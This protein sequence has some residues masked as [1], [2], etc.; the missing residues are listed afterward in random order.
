MLSF[1]SQPSSPGSPNDKK[2]RRKL[3]PIPPGTE[4]SPKQ[5]PKPKPATPPKPVVDKAAAEK[6][7]LRKRLQEKSA[8]QKKPPTAT[9]TPPPTGK[10]TKDEINTSRKPTTVVKKAQPSAASRK[11]AI[12]AVAKKPMQISKT[13]QPTIAVRKTQA[14]PVATSSARSTTV[15]SGPRSTTVTSGPKPTPVTSGPRPTPVT[16]T[17]TTK[18]PPLVKKKPQVAQKPKA[19]KPPE[20]VE[21]FG[22]KV[23]VEIKSLKQRIKEE[24]Q[25]VTATRRLRMDEME[26][27]RRMELELGQRDRERRKKAEQEAQEEALR[28]AERQ[29]QQELENERQR[30]N[31]RLATEQKL[32]AER[33]YASDKAKF[34]QRRKVTPQVAAI[35]SRMSPQA[36]P[37]R[38]RHKR[39]NSD[40]MIA[41]FSPIEEDRDI[42]GELQYKLG[43]ETR[44]VINDITKLSPRPGRYSKRLGTVTPP[45]RPEMEDDPVMS[46]SALSKS[47]EILSRFSLVERDPTLSSSLSESC[48]PMSSAPRSRT[49]N[50]FS[51]DD[52]QKKKEEK[53]QQLRLEI[54]KRKQQIEENARLQYELRKMAE[55][56][57][58]TRREFEEA[59]DM[60]QDHI[61]LRER[62]PQS[63]IIRPIDYEF[64]MGLPEQYSNQEY[65]A[66]RAMMENFEQAQVHPCQQPNYSSSEYLA[67]CRSDFPPNHDPSMMV[68]LDAGQYM[69]SN[70]YPENNYV[71]AH[72]PPYSQQEVVLYDSHPGSVYPAGYPNMQDH[73]L[74]GGNLPVGHQ[75]IQKQSERDMGAP[76]PEFSDASSVPT[77]AEATPNSERPPAMPLLEEV[78][79]RSRCL[80]RD[81]GSR[82][83]SDDMEKYF[84]AEGTSKNI[85]PIKNTLIAY[86]SLTNICNSLSSSYQTYIEIV[87]NIISTVGRAKY[88]CKIGDLLQVNCRRAS[89]VAQNKMLCTMPC[90][91]SAM[92]SPCIT[93]AS[94]IHYK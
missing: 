70:V 35:T 5:K 28:K 27:I 72:A 59:R 80:L 94:P 79:T 50:Y 18:I 53:K 16:A 63:G 87:N 7:L 92:Y 46:R 4:S 9:K 51:D 48:L 45:A 56:V 75:Y 25:I 42:E 14:P 17:K 47:S 77:D 66:Y 89:Y 68:P 38:A 24:L 44:K 93:P 49:P 1:Q 20:T 67:H 34:D 11:A 52:D 40:P 76:Y 71:S 43:L 57:D 21:I 82:P 36:S 60:Y 33:L 69:L 74:P 12:P 41:K 62:Q 65:V 88:F 37:R 15:T 32:M 22:I 54:R 39:Q 85:F 13:A 84:H 26:A 83:L 73:V 78:T 29:L 31:D 3:P 55:N 86:I 61:R 64:L 6:E 58:V 23:P 2:I 30:N 8:I 91:L 19:P 10:A 90:P 81:I